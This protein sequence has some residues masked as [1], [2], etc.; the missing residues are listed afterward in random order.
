[1][2]SELTQGENNHR[3]Y[4]SISKAPIAYNSSHSVPVLTVDVFVP[5]NTPLTRETEGEAQWR[6]SVGTASSIVPDDIEP[7]YV[8]I[9]RT[10]YP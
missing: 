10:Y 9:K 1:M 6:I 2:S 7:L 5:E 3:I 4:S 8:D